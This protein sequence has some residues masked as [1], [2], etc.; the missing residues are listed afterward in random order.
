MQKENN[1]QLS[2]KADKDLSD[3][4]NYTI[5]TFGLKQAHIYKNGLIETFLFLASNPKRGRDFFLNNGFSVK[6]FKYKSHVIFF[7]KTIKGILILRILGGKMDF[8]KH[9]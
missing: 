8:E 3:I 2:N 7:Q 5:E 9:L 1:Y 6:R 4:A